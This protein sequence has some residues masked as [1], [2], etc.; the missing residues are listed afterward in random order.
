MR[1]SGQNVR[2]IKRSAF[3]YSEIRVND[4]NYA[5]YAGL[6]ELAKRPYSAHFCNRWSYEA[7]GIVE[8]IKI[9]TNVFISFDKN[10]SLVPLLRSNHPNC[11]GNTERIYKLLHA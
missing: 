4:C 5:R 9:Q 6:S 8:E 1:V 7:E 11:I 3:N 2:I 10:G